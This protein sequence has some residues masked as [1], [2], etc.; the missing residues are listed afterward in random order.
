MISSYE[1]VPLLQDPDVEPGD[2]IHIDIFLSG[3]GRIAE[4]RLEIFHSY[5]GLFEEEVGSIRFMG[6]KVPRDYVEEHLEVEYDEQIIERNGEEYV[7]FFR[8]NDLEGFSLST[9]ERELDDVATNIHI[10]SWM[11]IPQSNYGPEENKPESS[12]SDI[13]YIRPKLFELTYEGTPPFELE[14]NISEN[15]DPGDYEIPCVLTYNTDLG[16]IKNS[17][18]NIQFHVNDRIEQRQPRLK[19]IVVLV[20]VLSLL[21]QAYPPLVDLFLDIQRAV[22]QFFLDLMSTPL[23]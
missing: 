9:M 23:F 11:K 22:V 3:G 12:G 16:V 17:R 8:N 5:D 7:F 19:Y 18:E 20:A 2:T 14:L 6:N 15:A 13:E 21:L 4:R 10:P 1:V